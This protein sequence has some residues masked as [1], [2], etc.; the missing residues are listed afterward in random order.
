MGALGRAR[1]EALQPSDGRH[2][3]QRLPYLNSPGPD[4]PAPGFFMPTNTV[5]CETSPHDLPRGRG[6]IYGRY[7]SGNGHAACASGQGPPRKTGGACQEFRQR[8][9]DLPASC[10]RKDSDPDARNLSSVHADPCHAFANEQR[11]IGGRQHCPPRGRPHAV[12]VCSFQDRRATPQ[13]GAAFQNP[14]GGSHARGSSAF[15]GMVGSLSWLVLSGRPSVKARAPRGAI[16][17]GLLRFRL[18]PISPG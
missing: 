7:V 4:H 1:R 13:V 15:K 11:G 9:C 16:R 12:R 5:E 14:N 2:V 3:S 18:V 6:Q 17:A 8:R 10:R